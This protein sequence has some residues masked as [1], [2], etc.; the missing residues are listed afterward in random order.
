[1]EEKKVKYRVTVEVLEENNGNL[2]ADYEEIYSQVVED[3]DL[4]RVIKAVNG[5]Y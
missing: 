3:L 1:M 2:D 4:E 5:M